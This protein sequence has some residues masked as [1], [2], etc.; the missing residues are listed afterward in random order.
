[1]VYTLYGVE[2]D[3]E[4]YCGHTIVQQ[5]ST[6]PDWMAWKYLCDGSG[7]R[8]SGRVDKMLDRCKYQKRT[9]YK[10]SLVFPS[11]PYRANDLGSFAHGHAI[12][13]WYVIWSYA[14]RKS[15]LVYYLLHFLCVIFS[16]LL[17][18]ICSNAKP[19]T[20][21]LTYPPYKILYEKSHILG[22]TWPADARVISQRA[23]RNYPGLRG[24]HQARVS[25]PPQV[26][27]PLL[28]HWPVRRAI[29]TE[30]L[31]LI[32]SLKQWHVCTAL[33]CSRKHISFLS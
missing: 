27:R 28:A 6:M 18:Q 33:R 8:Q 3:L 26:W 10:F 5:S 1:M 13:I 20:N 25:V 32:G 19:V 12:V 11:K 4:Q 30:H 29:L 2:L 21:I 23:G 7:H 31:A 14:H 15:Y 22:I 17:A 16:S 24:R 9:L